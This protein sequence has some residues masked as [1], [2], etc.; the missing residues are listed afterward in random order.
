MSATL[1]AGDVSA[2]SAVLACAR[3]LVVEA[4]SMQPAA[5]AGLLASPHLANLVGLHFDRG[6]YRTGFGTVRLNG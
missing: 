2:D 5:L 4:S 1:T 3:E 6:N